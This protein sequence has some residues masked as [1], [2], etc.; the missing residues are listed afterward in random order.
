MKDIELKGKIMRRVYVVAFVRRFLRPLVVKSVLFGVF[1]GSGFLVVSVPNVLGNIFNRQS[2][3]EAVMY[4]FHLVVQTEFIVQFVLL[5]II[6]LFAGVMIDILKR[7]GAGYNEL[8][9][10]H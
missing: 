1:L 5:G 10:S 7:F 3:G 2:F 8:A 6:I 9:I 4:V